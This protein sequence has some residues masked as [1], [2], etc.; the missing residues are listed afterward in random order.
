MNYVRKPLQELNLIDNFLF[1]SVMTH[2][3][4]GPYVGRSI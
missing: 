3:V 2:P 4:Y 1:G